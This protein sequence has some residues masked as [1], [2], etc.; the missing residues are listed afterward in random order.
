MQ[1]HKRW[2]NSDLPQP[3]TLLESTDMWT[4][5]LLDAKVWQFRGGAIMQEV[6]LGEDAIII[7]TGHSER[8]NPKLIRMRTVNKIYFGDK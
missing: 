7:L 1:N 8:R 6:E 3:R 4:L 2:K 5:E